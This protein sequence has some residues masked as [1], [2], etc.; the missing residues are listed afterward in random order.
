M[1]DLFDTVAARRSIRRYKSDPVPREDIEKMLDAAMRAPSACNTRPWEFAVVTNLEKRT[2]LAKIS[3]YVKHVLEAPVA[4]IVC[5]LPET[6][7]KMSSKFFQQDC[8]AATE[9]L[10]LAAAALGYGTCWCGIYT[11]R[12]RSNAVKAILGVESTPF[13]MITLGLPDEAPSPRGAYDPDKV[14][15]YD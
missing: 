2:A 5:A 14:K 9:N 1:T 15:Y 11:D 6:Q 12:K 4:L 8:G 7:A 13:C 3:P 10:L